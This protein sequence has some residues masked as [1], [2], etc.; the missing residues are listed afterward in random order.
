MGK[1]GPFYTQVEAA[2]ISQIQHS[3]FS[4]SEN[5]REV[6]GKIVQGKNNAGVTKPY[7]LI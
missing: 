1:N 6:L 7:F 5:N 4:H 2:S 3:S